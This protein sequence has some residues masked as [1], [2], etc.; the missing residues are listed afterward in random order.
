MKINYFW[1]KNYEVNQIG[2]RLNPVNRHLS[3]KINLILENSK[4][5]NVVDPLS[6]RKLYIKYDEIYLIE[7]MDN[8]SKIYTFN[9]KVFYARGRLKD[10]ES[11]KIDGISRINNSTML[12]LTDVVNFRQGLYARLEVETKD[13][14]IHIVSRHY[15][16]KIKEVLQCLKN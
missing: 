7:A 13:G 16:Q 9:R 1:D 10:F 5:L 14:E 4:K 15:A 2:I 12:N 8:F 3:L 11:K 6:D